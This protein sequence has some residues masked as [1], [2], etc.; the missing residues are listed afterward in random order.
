MSSA[1]RRKLR[2]IRGGIQPHAGRTLQ[3][4]LDHQRGEL[5]AVG[6]Q[7]PLHCAEGAVPV[8]QAR[9]RH[10]HVH[11]V[12]HHAGE[13]PTEHLDA[14]QAGRADRFPVECA[15]QR[16]KARAP[17]TRLCVILHAHLDGGLDRRRSVV[18]VEHLVEVAWRDGGELLGQ[19]RGG[20]VGDAGQRHVTQSTGLRL[21]RGHEP[22]RVVSERGD[23]PR[24]VAIDEPAAVVQD[25]VRSLGAG[26]HQRVVARAPL[27]HR[28]VGMPD[29]LPV[30]GQDGGQ[31]R[32][33]AAHRPRSTP[34]VGDPGA[35]SAGCS[36]VGRAAGLPGPRAEPLTRANAG[37][38]PNTS[39]SGLER[40]LMMFIK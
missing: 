5:S 15:L 16:E 32:A 35:R 22:R 10:R 18:G 11:C 37:L 25:Q 33:C 1:Q 20:R 2:E 29:V 36:Q 9:H 14:A 39:S 3:D 26:H 13:G 38:Y 19:Q 31:V 7:H 6:F 21:E 8:G 34:S 30:G 28:R 4:R 27:V 40:V 17:V 23:P 12:E 24:A